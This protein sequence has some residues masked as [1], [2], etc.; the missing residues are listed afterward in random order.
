[1]DRSVAYL[2]TARLGQI[3]FYAAAVVMIVKYMTPAEQGYYYTF[4]SVISL[5]VFV[6]LGLA[7]VIVSSTSHEWAF[8][9]TD[10]LLN[11]VGD[12][13][14]HSRLIS[15][16]RAAIKWFGVASLIFIPTVGVAGWLFFSSKVTAGVA[17]QGPWCA[18]VALTG[19]SISMTPFNAILEGCNQIVKI[20]RTRM[21]QTIL[22]GLAICLGLR[23]GVGL[24]VAAIAVAARLSRNLYLVFVE[25]RHFFSSFLSRMAGPTVDWFLEIWPM[26]WRLGVSGLV[27]YFLNSMYNPVM[28]HYHGA[29]VAGQTGLTLQMTTGMSVVAMSWISTKVPRFGGL[30]AKREYRE[31]DHLWLRAS[32]VSIS[33]IA[34]GASVFWLF[35]CWA[36]HSGYGF[37]QRV[38]EPLPAGLF[39]ISAVVAQFVQCLV[40]Y[41][42][43]HRK[44]PIMVASVSICIGTGLLVWQFGK[45]W[46]PTGAASGSLIVITLGAI[47]IFGI[48]KHCRSAWHEVTV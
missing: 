23:F 34:I 5:Q 46:G 22:E 12:P 24:W 30:I 25:Y 31:L 17:W 8:L 1:M 40:Y 6:D 28:F 37:A 33:M 26:Q 18:L 15:L 2:L 48:W 16:G 13:K 19:V 7:I 14:S 20:N 21:E 45:R 42:R 47:W 41:L 11:I 27:T 9:R 38:L 36:R 3:G 39:I 4:Y 29:V 35:V 32:L 10:M 43:A 44:E